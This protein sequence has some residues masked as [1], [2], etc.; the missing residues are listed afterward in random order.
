MKAYS[1][2]AQ[3]LVTRFQKKFHVNFPRS[4]PETIRSHTK[5]LLLAEILLA[6]QRIESK[7]PKWEDSH[8]PRTPG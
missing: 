5:Q 8:M 6:L 1:V 7:I 4:S 3:E 2:E